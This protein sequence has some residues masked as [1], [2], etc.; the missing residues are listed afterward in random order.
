MPA[1]YIPYTYEYTY[2]CTPAER[3][4]AVGL[5]LE[6]RS[7]EGHRRLAS[8]LLT[9]NSAHAPP[10]ARHLEPLA[11]RLRLLAPQPHQIH[12]GS[13]LVR[14]LGGSSS[15]RVVRSCCIRQHTSAYVSIRQ[16]TQPHQIHAIFL[17]RRQ[18]HQSRPQLL[19]RRRRR[20][21]NTSA[22]VSIRQHTSALRKHTLT[23]IRARLLRRRRRRCC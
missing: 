4:L 17:M 3:E 20:C 21:Q 10:R 13:F 12:A 9:L 8:L 5:L 23:R 14:D 18:Q 6:R 15:I 16:H 1:I 22:Y 7:D 11:K 19:W 2:I